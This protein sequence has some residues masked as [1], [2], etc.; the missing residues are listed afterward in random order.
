[1]GQPVGAPGPR[2]APRQL[3]L[4]EGPGWMIAV[5]LGGGA[6]PATQS[7]EDPELTGT[8]TAPPVTVLLMGA[9]MPMPSHLVLRAGSVSLQA[10][11]VGLSHVRAASTACGRGWQSCECPCTA[12]FPGPCP[13][14]GAD[15]WSS[16]GSHLTLSQGSKWGLLTRLPWCLW[17][18]RFINVGSEGTL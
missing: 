4:G 9:S 18:H 2:L 12:A 11:A 15:P 3:Q 6:G 7:G 10:C 1:M 13:R 16:G 17:V 14:C 5:G 8:I